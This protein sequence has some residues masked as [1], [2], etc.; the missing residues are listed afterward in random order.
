MNYVRPTGIPEL[1]AALQDDGA[2][3][4]CGGTDLLVKMRRGLVSPRSLIDVSRLDE[5]RGIEQVD[6]EIRIGAAVSE[7]EILRSRLVVERLPLLAHVLKRLAAVEIRS[8][9]SLGGNLVNASPAADS[10]VPLLL[11]EAR[12]RLVGPDGERWLPIDEFFVGPG[13]TALAAGEFI[14]EI[15][16]PAPPEGARF[17]YRKVGRRRALVISIASLGMLFR[18][19]EGTV[20]LIRI[21]AGSVDPTPVRIH[22]VERI[23][24]GSPLDDGRIREAAQ[25]ASRAVSPIDDV[26]AT[27]TYR[28][29]VIG[30]LLEHFLTQAKNAD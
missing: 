15:G 21:A 13:R 30:D 7:N 12:L 25:A 28:R 16:I 23:L 3:I 17:S 8:R 19:N 4:V 5:L 2:A 22:D 9:G 29:Q 14:R 24:L 27:A 6:G 18:L 20:D 10:A 1:L 26:R 11:Y